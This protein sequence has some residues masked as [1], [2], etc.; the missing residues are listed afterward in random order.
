MMLKHDLQ[1][2]NSR[3]DDRFRKQLFLLH[4]LSPPVILKLYNM[5][6]ILAIQ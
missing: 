4:V 2:V 1:G 6:F 5:E 3:H